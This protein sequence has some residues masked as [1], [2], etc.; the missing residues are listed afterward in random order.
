[1]SRIF[2]IIFISLG[3]MSAYAQPLPVSVNEALGKA[4]IEPEAMAYA[5]VP[6]H[7][8]A[9]PVWYQPNKSL[10]PASTMKLVTTVV[11]LTQLGPN[12]R[13]RTELLTDGPIRNG[14]L[15]GNL[16]LRGLADPDLD[17]PA[18]WELLY[19]LRA[20]GVRRVRGNV[21]LDRSF[22][23]PERLDIGV[24]PFDEAPEFQYNVIP[25]ALF[26]N[27]NTLR[28]ELVADASR[29]HIRTQPPLWGIS[30]RSRQ[31]V[32]AGKC[33]DW[34]KGWQPAEV[35]VSSRTRRAQVSFNGSFPANCTTLE[36]LELIDRDIVA[37]RLVRQLWADMGG[38]L[39]GRVVVGRAA[40]GA[41]VIAQH[42][43]RPLAEVLRHMNKASD[44]PLTRLIYLSLGATAPADARAQYE[45]T[46]EA[47]AVQV[48]RWFA[49]QGIATEGMVLDN[50]SGLS[51][52]ERMTPQQMTA[53]LAI[54][55]R[56]SYAP[57]LLASMPLVGVDG[58]MRNRLKGTRAEARAR[59][60][61]GTLR[62]AVAVA[63]YV[64]DADEKPWALSAMINHGTGSVGRPALD[65]L[66]EWVATH[67][68]PEIAGD[69]ATP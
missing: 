3:A 16:V 39:D 46:A 58:T 65:A 53:M 21:V 41:R 25:D 43:S 60:K 36:N 44:N 27:G 63:G 35:A 9:T 26:L 1:M 12:Y 28:Y 50:G 54:A 42:Q 56:A 14:E 62:D 49:D 15:R 31:T 4:G 5:L 64:Y 10:P 38:R 11:A 68:G 7:E 57:E 59:I 61:T 32:A 30:V 69:V 17:V 52:S 47:S 13:G 45:T 22:F 18:L 19:R 6:L 48:K 67:R 55:W 66:I 37:N 20:E 8:G 51:R 34:D 40:A 23:V 24:S 33:K 29:V 2:W